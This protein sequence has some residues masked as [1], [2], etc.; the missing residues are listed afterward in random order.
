[1]LESLGAMKSDNAKFGTPSRFL[2]CC[3]RV[4]NLSNT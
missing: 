3:L 2:D 4:I 1:M